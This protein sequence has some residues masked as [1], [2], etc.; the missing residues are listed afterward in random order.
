MTLL[1]IRS[2]FVIMSGVVGYYIGILV[3]YPSVNGE[4]YDYSD[5][6]K[7]VEARG[8]LKAVAADLLSLALLTP[9]GP[10]HCRT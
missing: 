9:P 6:F 2:L 8:I 7:Q 5:L 3:Q 1:F 4:V 10:E